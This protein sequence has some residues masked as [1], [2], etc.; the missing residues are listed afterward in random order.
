M[1]IAV[2]M[3]RWVGD[4]V[5][6]TP[7]LRSLRGQFPTARITG[8]MRPVVADLLAGTN[9]LDDTISYDR[10]RRDPAASFAAAA[11]AL[12]TARPDVAVIFPNSLSSAFLAWRGR[13][14]RRVGAAGHWR[15][16]LLT[17]TVPPYRDDRGRPEIVPPPRA[18]MDIVAALGVP[19]GPLDVELVATPDDRVAAEAVLARLFPGRRGPLVV[20]NDN[21][22]NGAARAWGSDKLAALA[23]WLV[24]RLPEPRVVVHCGP[25][26]RDQARE[27][28]TQAAHPAV[29]GLQDVPDLPIGL[30]KAIFA[31]ASLAVSSDSGP[32]HIAAAFGVPTVALLGPTD[33]R[34]G[35]SAPDRCV[36]IRRDLAC[37]PCGKKE[38]PLGHHDCLRLV[39]VDEVGHAT[40]DLFARFG[41]GSPVTP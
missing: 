41:P 39:T 19:S 8:V 31:Q 11:R 40:L 5:M 26:D 32:R 25:G 20:L 36:E 33:P 6:A 22:S 10:H 7:A 18:C 4:A 16:W 1:H 37:S 2:I 15:R 12:R 23:R 29:A 9:W 13:A 27:V 3:P 28:V 24:E 34:L 30:S 17:D 38:C 35:R 14:R 21:S